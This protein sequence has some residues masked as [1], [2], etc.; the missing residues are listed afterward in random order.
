[1]QLEYEMLALKLDRNFSFYNRYCDECV[2]FQGHSFYY[3]LF[4]IVFLP[5]IDSKRCTQISCL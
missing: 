2:L 3:F 5:I 4:C 1:M